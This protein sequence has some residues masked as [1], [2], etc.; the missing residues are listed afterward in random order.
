MHKKIYW[1]TL[2]FPVLFLFILDILLTYD[3]YIN[4]SIIFSILLIPI[5][6]I[7]FYQI[8]KDEPVGKSIIYYLVYGIASGIFTF[9]Y[10]LILLKIKPYQGDMAGLAI[11]AYPFYVMSY[12]FTSGFI[13]L[14]LKKIILKVNSTK[15]FNIFL[16]SLVGGIIIFILFTILI[17]FDNLIRGHQIGI[18]NN[19]GIIPFVIIYGIVLVLNYLITYY[20]P[21]NKLKI[22]QE[23]RS[24]FLVSFIISYL[25]VLTSNYLAIKV[26]YLIGLVYFFIVI[27]SLILIAYLKSYSK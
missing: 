22:L 9:L 12:F 14:L 27:S 20:F 3:I 17:I 16:E 7:S 1:M 5:F 23:K 21:I 11:I 19:P 18:T 10:M 6:A 13:I 24:I 2:L 15:K 4:L 25:L 8:I 26:Y